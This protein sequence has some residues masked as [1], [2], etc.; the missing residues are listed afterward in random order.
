VS[1]CAYVC[2]CMCVC[3]CVCGERGACVAQYY[4]VFDNRTSQCVLYH[5]K[6]GIVDFHGHK[7]LMKNVGSFFDPTHHNYVFH[8]EYVCTC[9]CPCMCIC[10]CLVVFVWVCVGANVCVCM[11]VH[12]CVCFQIFVLFVCVSVFVCVCLCAFECVYVCV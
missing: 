5:L 12:V 2:V 11:C 9:V 1:L 10:V 8:S 3:V 4:S 7:A 6:R